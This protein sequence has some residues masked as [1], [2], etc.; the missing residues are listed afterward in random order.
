MVQPDGEHTIGCGF[1]E[2]QLACIGVEE[3]GN[4]SWNIHYRNVL[5]GYTDEKLITEK[6]TY[7][8]INKIKV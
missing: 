5:L 8:H 2:L 1:Q 3:I 6:E 4:G 7:L